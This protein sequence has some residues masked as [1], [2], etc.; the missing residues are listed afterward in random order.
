MNKM[1]SSLIALI[2]VLTLGYLYFNGIGNSDI[3]D[4]NSYLFWGGSKNAHHVFNRMISEQNHVAWSTGYHTGSPVPLGAVGP[5]KYT[6]KLQGMIQ[7]TEISKVLKEAVGDGVN[8]ILLIGDGMG[9]SLLS[10]PI[11][12]NIA[13][14]SEE[15]TYFEIIMNEGISSFVLNHPY[16]EI[17]PSSATS[18]TSI[19]CGSKTRVGMI[20]VDH[21]G[22]ELKSILDVAEEKG[23]VTGLITESTIVDATPVGFYGHSSN[24][25]DFLTF[26]EQLVYDNDI[27]LIFSG[28]GAYFIPQKSRLS[29]ME[30][31]EDLNSDLD[32]ISQRIDDKNL[33][34]DASSKGYKLVNTREELLSLDAKSKKIFGIFAAN[35]M[36]STIDRDNE[37]TGEP[38]LVEMTQKGIEILSNSTAGF[39]LM[40]EEARID[41]E[42]HDN[43]AGAVLKAVT[44]FNEV[45]GAGY[46]YYASNKENTL[47]VFTA[48][49]ETGGMSFTYFGIPKDERI[50]LQLPSGKEYIRKLSSLTFEEYL[51]I[52]NQNKSIYKIFLEADTPE[53]LLELLLNNSGYDISIEEAEQLFPLIQ[54]YKKGK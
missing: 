13:K 31:F 40:V 29:E 53:H 28:G 19:A 49:H 52:S 8:V 27:E 33:L 48:D 14:G 7:N 23:M 35:A 2:A 34:K 6:D 4:D 16:G 15:K 24:R 9:I 38:S 45:V 41:F 30:G 17:V 3:P 32:Q 25:H 43:D 1:T 39:F 54:K 12:H 37:A 46:N 18:A 47:I 44:E 26:A 5:K 36:N 20:G 10:M 51:T 50:P 22:Y 42:A 21:D 11:Y